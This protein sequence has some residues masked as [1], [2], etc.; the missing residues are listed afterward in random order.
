MGV[1]N[2]AGMITGE[3]RK[4]SYHVEQSRQTRY[5]TVN[6]HHQVQGFVDR[7]IVARTD[8]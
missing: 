4:R 5:C 8:L 1:I 2:K 7:M 3:K 6:G